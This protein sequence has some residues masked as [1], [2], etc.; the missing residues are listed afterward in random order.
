ML[1]IRGSHP[2][3]AHTSWS[4][5]CLS[6][7]LGINKDFLPTSGYSLPPLLLAPAW[8][9]MRHRLG[10]GDLCRNSSINAQTMAQEAP[11]FNAPRGCNHVH[12]DCLSCLWLQGPLLHYPMWVSPRFCVCT[13]PAPLAP[14]CGT[15]VPSIGAKQL[16]YLKG[17]WFVC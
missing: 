17:P 1:H 10:P 2:Q 12:T 16:L 13:E 3:C 15:S 7:S 5:A 8:A 14:G 9:A 11:A 6:S 4:Q